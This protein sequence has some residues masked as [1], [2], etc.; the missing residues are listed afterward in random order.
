MGIIYENATLI[1]EKLP[2]HVR[3]IAVSKT[4]TIDEI[5]EAY[6]A[7]IRD[8]GENYVQELM[9]KQPYLPSDI[10]WHFI[11]HLQRNKVK[12]IA[13]FIGYIHSV[14]SLALLQ[15]IEKQ[16]AKINRSLS[17]L[18]QI[19]IAL[20]GSKFGFSTDETFPF[21][22]KEQ[23]KQFSH[24]VFAGVMG[25]GSLTDD[26]S[27]TRQEY[28]NLKNVFDRLKNQ[29]FYDYP[30]FKE[31]SMGM[32]HDYDI[33]IEEGATMVRIGTAIFGERMKK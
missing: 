20:D 12:Y 15:E 3:M 11:G 18:L 30:E 5:K 26:K 16:A 4:K 33:A 1:L 9:Q 29:I 25:M 10:T 6:E 13:P 8:F 19:S 27:L 22:Q 14:D 24:I 7:G 31:I 23:Y 2:S 17:C 21:L 28:K 32:S